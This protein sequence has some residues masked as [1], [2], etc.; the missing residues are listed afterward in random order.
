LRFLAPL[1]HKEAVIVFD[2]W[3][4]HHLE[5]ADLG[6]KKAFDEFLVANPQWQVHEQHG[7]D[8]LSRVFYLVEKHPI[9][10]TEPS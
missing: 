8:T 2:D 6:E 7:Y 1:L 9:D 5:D 3:A 4:S 10:H